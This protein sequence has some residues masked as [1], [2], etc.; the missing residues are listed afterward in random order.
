MAEG[1]L[2]RAEVLALVAPNGVG[3]LRRVCTIARRWMALRPELRLTIACERWQADALQS[4]PTARW[5]LARSELRFGVIGARANTSLR[6][7]EAGPV[8]DA[9]E[10][11]VVASGLLDGAD[12]VV[13]DNL[14]S[15]AARHPRTVFVG[16]FLWSDVLGEA[17]GSWRDRE[18]RALEEACPPMLHV[19]DL[20]MAAVRDRPE[21]VGLGWTCDEPVPPEEFG[22]DGPIAVLGGQTGLLDGELAAAA[23]LL[24][25]AGWPV[26]AS[27][28]VIGRLSTR[29]A[30]RVAPFGFQREDFRAA[31]AVVCRPG[32]GTLTD[33][34]AAG[35]PIVAVNDG[36]DVELAHNARRVRELGI[37]EE[38]VGPRPQLLG[39]VERVTGADGVAMR[40]RIA[41]LDR[42]GALA[43]AEWLDQRLQDAAAGGPRSDIAVGGLA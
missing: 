43:A 32:V 19:A 31:A 38:V 39:A 14:L 29:L 30:R 5:V 36:V 35:T 25:A 21:A 9:W 20:A 40:D 34:V 17:T 15:I 27:T 26:A 23:E 3:H 18:R 8:F 10:E 4:T 16:N 6:V 42:S 37:G 2:A 13:T 41:A 28:P 22:G 1:S 7:L 12:I 11:R 24:V 33:A